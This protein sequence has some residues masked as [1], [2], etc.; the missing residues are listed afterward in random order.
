VAAS[1]AIHIHANARGR[2]ED[3]VWRHE[4]VEL[5]LRNKAIY[6][7]IPGGRGLLKR[8]KATYDLISI[9]RVQ[10]VRFKA[11]FGLISTISG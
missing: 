6:G 9:E 8:I 7:L 2:L 1:R 11:I 3:G 5:V 4:E 10:F